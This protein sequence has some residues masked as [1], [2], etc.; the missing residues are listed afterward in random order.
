[1]PLLNVHG[2]RRQ[3]RQH[4][5][6]IQNSSAMVVALRLGYFWQETWLLAVVRKSSEVEYDKAEAE[7]DWIWSPDPA[8]V[9]N[10]NL[11]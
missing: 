3:P 5:H 10:A 1:V 9:A 6:L 4:G 7:G 2:T 11:S 8:S